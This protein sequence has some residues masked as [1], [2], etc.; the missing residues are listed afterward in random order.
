MRQL[1]ILYK[2]GQGQFR[3]LDEFVHSN[4]YGRKE[5]Y[6]AAKLMRQRPW[7]EGAAVRLDDELFNLVTFDQEALAPHSFLLDT[8]AHYQEDL[9]P[10]NAPVDE[11]T[12]FND[13]AAATYGSN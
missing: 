6:D 5:I 4:L 3:P 12:I 7:L 10:V 2:R 1:R 9:L 11:Q 8:F 13:A